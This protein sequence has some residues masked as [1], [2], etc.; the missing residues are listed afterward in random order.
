MGR[1]LV[2]LGLAMLYLFVK[3]SHVGVDMNG[4]AYSLHCLTACG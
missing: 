3:S 1:F 4:L 2:L